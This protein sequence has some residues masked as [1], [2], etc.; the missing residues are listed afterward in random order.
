MTTREFYLAVAA[1]DNNELVIKANELIEKLDAKNEKRKSADS[2][3]KKESASRRNAVLGFLKEHAGEFF[4]RDEIASALE[5]SDGQAT[6]A[7]TALVKEGAISKKEIKIE[8]TKKVAY[9]FSAE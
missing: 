1:S 8:K 5:I 4:T 3:A 7:C 9:G 6:S 2:K